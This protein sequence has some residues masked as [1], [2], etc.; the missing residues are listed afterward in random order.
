MRAPG[1]IVNLWDR[2]RERILDLARWLGDLP[3]LVTRGAALA[4]L[5]VLI[6]GAIVWAVLE[7]PFAG[8]EA[9]PN[10]DQGP[11][12]STFEAPDQPSAVGAL[13]F[14]VA[15]T[16]N[17]TRVP[18]ADPAT[19]AAAVA[20]AT[21]PP[22]SGGT[23]A[24]AAV[25]VGSE[26]WQ[27]GIA[28]AVLTGPPLRFPL[29]VSTESRAPDATTDA[30]ERLGPRGSGPGTAALYTVGDLAAPAGLKAERIGGDEAATRAAA[31]DEL[32]QKLTG[33]EPTS[34]VVV[35]SQNP[36][37]AMPAAAWAARSGDPVF[38]TT[39]DRAPV[40]TLQA[41]RRYPK[42]DVFVLGPES[43][44]SAEAFRDLR[45]A[46]ADIKR[47]EGPDPVSNA[48]AFARYADGEFGWDINDPGHG[49]VIASTQRP[50]DAAAGASLSA[51]GDWGPLLLV[52]SA[53]SLPPELESFLLDIKPGYTD[54][55]TRAV[56]NHIWLMGDDAAISATAQAQ[57]DELAELAQVG[58]GSGGVVTDDE[59]GTPQPSGTI[60][61]NGS[62]ETE[63]GKTG[64]STQT[65]TTGKDSGQ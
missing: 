30:L 61:P 51:S 46:S 64:T 19:D 5:A 58:P 27:S 17:T 26:D 43:A 11:L 41:I 59:P 63:P 38:F 40:A 53:R 9:V 4:V 23:A 39:R 44:V 29:L 22:G 3:A 33:E 56:Y 1:P 60:G 7:G 42:A 20:L 12:V 36:A 34:I 57:I 45:G 25:M 6:A 31:I 24:S 18:G 37:Y 28:A 14:P 21:H 62:A 10:R 35:S 16:R 49:L 13:G 55:P 47:V 2:L 32:R 54:D 48:V 15:A 65:G 52:E 8:D 50:L